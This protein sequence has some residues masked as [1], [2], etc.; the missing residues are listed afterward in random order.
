MSGIGGLAGYTGNALQ[1]ATICEKMQTSLKKRGPDEHGTYISEEVCLLNTSTNFPYTGRGPMRAMLG[2]KV[3]ILVFD[4]ELYNKDELINELKTLGYSIPD[5]SD[6]G[7]VLYGYMAW[8]KSC[9]DRFLGMYAFAIWDSQQLFMARDR[10]G[11]KPLYYSLN[12][13]GFAF[14]SD[15]R[16]LLCHPG[17]KPIIDSQGIAELILLGPGRTPGT[18]PFRDIWELKPGHFATYSMIKG[19]TTDQYWKLRA[20]THRDTFKETTEKVAKIL[21]DSISRQT[22]GSL[23]IG[24]FL[25]GGLDSSA[26][27][28]ISKSR[29]TFSVDYIG[30]DTHFSPT[31]F[32]PDDDNAFIKEMVTAL[33]ASHSRVVLGSDELADALTPAMYARGF[34]G[35]GDVDSA[36]LLFCQKVKEFVPIALTG[37]GADEIF[38]GYPW[39]Q[40][41][42]RLNADTFPWSQKTDYR[43]RFIAPHILKNLNPDEYIRTRFEKTISASPTLYDDNPKEKRIRQMYNLNIFWFLQNLAIRNESMS[44]AAGLTVRS[45]FLD[46]RLVEYMYNVPW[47]YKNHKDR[48]KGLLRES[49]KNHLPDSVLWRKKSPFPKTHNPAY[50]NRVTDMIKV[51]DNDAPIYTIISKEA[52]TQLLDEDTNN[53]WYGQLMTKPQTIAYFLQINAWMAEFN[54]IVRT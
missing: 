30:N 35:M 26:I 45:P 25:S 41:E 38:G 23:K 9:L 2:Q 5:N 49:L 39:Y 17:V 40:Q 22:G 48:E 27:A 54:V 36:L 24:T 1:L 28:A 3:Y 37:E 43:S 34:P 44:A 4:G 33:G 50:M 7:V 53:P 6:A 20:K 21:N 31:E 29:N 52:I 18:T 47:E 42:E 12:T 10:L 16:T 8:G 32:Q 13:N 19:F 11:L 51:V 15:V 46:H 14:A